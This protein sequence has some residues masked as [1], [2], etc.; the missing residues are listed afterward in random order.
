M[1]SDRIRLKSLLDKVVTAEEA[2]RFIK[3]G[4]TI[5]MSGFTLAGEAR[6]ARWP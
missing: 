2:A 6:A 5:G 3:N 1:H 4:M